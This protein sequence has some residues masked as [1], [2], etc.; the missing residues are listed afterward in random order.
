MISK[1][2]ILVGL[3]LIPFCEGFSADLGP[4]DL[5]PEQTPFVESAPQPEM[6]AQQDADKTRNLLDLAVGL[7]KKKDYKAAADIYAQIIQLG[8]A[9]MDHYNGLMQNLDSLV[10]RRMK[11]DVNPKIIT[12][13][14][15][16]IMN[17]KW[18]TGYEMMIARR[19]HDYLQKSLEA[20]RQ[21]IEGKALELYRKRDYKAAADIY[22]QI[23]QSEDPKLHHYQSLLF[24]LYY[25][26]R[27]HRPLEMSTDLVLKAYDA[28]MKAEYADQ[29]ERK[30]AVTVFNYFQQRAQQIQRITP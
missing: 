18:E 22:A 6:A 23:I 21:L 15:K 1:T 14:Y 7:R 11:L 8:N 29:Y 30:V 5:P 3:C 28:V 13:A 24:C 16:A 19:V 10:C 9:S 27:R 17:T 20:D 2:K 4:T 26:L 12:D 25:L